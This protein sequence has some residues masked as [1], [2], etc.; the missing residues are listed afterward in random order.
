[1]KL[2]SEEQFKEYHGMTRKELATV[3][4][5]E[6]YLHKEKERISNLIEDVTEG[7]MILPKYVHTS[8][9]K[10]KKMLITQSKL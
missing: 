2:W 5:N 9:Y 4:S 8:E 7:Q 6:L 1:M 3:I 10:Q